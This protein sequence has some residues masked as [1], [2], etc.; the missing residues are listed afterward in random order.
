MKK[1]KKEE[2]NNFQLP[3]WIPPKN[4]LN[5]VENVYEA[6]EAVASA[7]RIVTSV[8]ILL[9]S[10]FFTYYWQLVGRDGLIEFAF[11]YL[12]LRQLVWYKI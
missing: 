1:S 4:A 12:V 6:N 11:V 5:T 3:H 9:F 7:R 8:Y 10:F 2:E